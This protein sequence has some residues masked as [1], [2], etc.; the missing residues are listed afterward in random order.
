VPAADP[1]S[2]LDSQASLR[3]L[4]LFVL[5]YLGL[6][7]VWPFDFARFWSPIL[8][9]ML[10]YSADAVIRSGEGLARRLPVGATALALLALLFILNGEEDLIQLGNYARRLNYVSDSLSSGVATII[11]RSPD[12]ASTYV[13]TMNGDDHFALAWYF[14]QAPGPHGEPGGGRRYI[15]YSPLPHVQKKGAGGGGARGGEETV[16]ELLLRLM[17]MADAGGTTAADRSRIYLFSYFAHHD[18]EGVFANL[19]RT[20]PSEMAAWSVQKVRQQEI[21]VAV[22]EMRRQQT[23]ASRP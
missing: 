19:Q 22:R 5:L 20:H 17:A 1:S 4:D 13:A 18:A 7:L 3:F 12:P 23:A 10:V 16:E 21:I 11:R 15:P 2:A 8:P 6:Y 14:T 9:L